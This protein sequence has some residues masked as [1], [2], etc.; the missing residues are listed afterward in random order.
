LAQRCAELL[1]DLGFSLYAILSVCHIVVT[2]DEKKKSEIGV[3]TDW[4][5]AIEY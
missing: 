3:S 1:N 5:V 2:L 4:Y